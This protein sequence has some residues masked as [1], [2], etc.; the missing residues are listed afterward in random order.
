M[1]HFAV[2]L[3][4]LAPPQATGPAQIILFRHAEKPADEANPH[5]SPEGVRRARQLVGFLSTNPV[6]NKHGKPVAIFATQTTKDGDGQRTQET[7]A[8]AAAALKLRV[9]TP[10]LGKD[11]QQLAKLILGNPAYAGK[12]VL[13]CWNHDVLPELAAEL[14][15]SPTPPAWKA[16]EYDQVYVISFR[17]KAATL[18]VMAENL[19][20]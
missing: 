2:V 14:G 18:T 17:G 6:V 10:Y 12:T 16:K 11:Y 15:V 5:L 8:P 19:R 9:Q 13:I 4:L 3:A 20:P 1:T 7:V